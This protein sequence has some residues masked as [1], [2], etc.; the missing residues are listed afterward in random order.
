[1]DRIPWASEARQD[2]YGAP[3]CCLQGQRQW[4]RPKPVLGACGQHAGNQTGRG[5][6]GFSW[7]GVSKRS[8]SMM[9]HT[10]SNLMLA[11]TDSRWNVCTQPQPQVLSLTHLACILEGCQHC[12]T[13]AGHV[14]GGR[15]PATPLNPQELGVLGREGGQHDSSR[16]WSATFSGASQLTTS[17]VHY[18]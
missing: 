2:R 14:Q 4:H 16:H 15:G 6:V 9:L 17:G 13:C 8:H 11:L 5:P 7:W 3:T 10:W 18:H 1:V 12:I